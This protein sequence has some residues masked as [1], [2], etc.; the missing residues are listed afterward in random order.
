MTTSGGPVQWA[1]AHIIRRI[2]ISSQLNQ[3]LRSFGMS[4]HRSPV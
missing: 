1:V 2:D 4:L 3:R